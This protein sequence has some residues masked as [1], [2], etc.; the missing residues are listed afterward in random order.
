MDPAVGLA[1]LAGHDPPRV[2]AFPPSSWVA[3]Q[4]KPGKLPVFR[5]GIGYAECPFADSRRESRLDR[6]ST[7]RQS[8]LGRGTDML[9]LVAV[10]S[11]LLVSLGLATS[12]PAHPPGPDGPERPKAKAKGREQAKKKGGPGPRADLTKAYE[13]LRRLRA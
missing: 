2:G 12:F 6:L 4:E 10:V 9:K 3:I 11:S 1:L 8:N 5:P 7:Q 13:L